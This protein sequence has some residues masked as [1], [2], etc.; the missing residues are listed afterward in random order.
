MA[1]I[2]RQISR[3]PFGFDLR[4]LVHAVCSPRSGRAGFAADLF[5]DD[6][7]TSRAIASAGLAALVALPLLLLSSVVLAAPLAVPAA[8]GLGYLAVSRALSTHR[9]RRANLISSAVLCGLVGW[10]VLLLLSGEGPLSSAGLIAALM[11]PLFAAAPAFARSLIAR[12][13][14]PIALANRDLRDAALKRIARLEE[15]TPSE[16]VLVLDPDGTV[17]AASSAA[18]KNL[19]LLPDAFEHHL[20]GLAASDGMRRVFDAVARDRNDAAPIVAELTF[21]VFANAKLVSANL[22]PCGDG[23]LIMRLQEPKAIAPS[24]PVLQKKVVGE[25]PPISTL[26]ASVCDIGEAVTF[27]LRRSAAKAKARKV[28]MTSA[29]DP[30]LAAACDRQVGRRIVHLLI[31]GGLDGCDPDGAIQLV[32][33]RLKGTVLLRT[34]TSPRNGATNAVRSIAGWPDMT[35]LRNLIDGVGGTLVVDRENHGTVASVRLPLS[36]TAMSTCEKRSC[37]S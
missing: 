30:E 29:A 35:A 21:D 11:T 13:A 27:A 17:L 14:A 23:T 34:T 10:L 16:Q 5:A 25:T 28:S 2:A 31:D 9:Q 33:R 4:R 22:C 12:R 20:Y 15:L 6:D 24:V 3:D 18:R 36:V 32:A 26:T 19:G 8:I 37:H 7:L 1:S